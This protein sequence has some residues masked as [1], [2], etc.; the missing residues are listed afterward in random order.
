MWFSNQIDLTLLILFDQ[1]KLTMSYV[2]MSRSCVHIFQMLTNIHKIKK[3]IKFLCILI[4][5]ILFLMGVGGGE[6]GGKNYPTTPSEKCEKLKIGA[7]RRPVPIFRGLK[8]SFTHFLKLFVW[9]VCRSRDMG[10]LLGVGTIF[11]Y[12]PI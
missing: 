8:F 1:I 10:V 4:L 11:L 12:F 9:V 5:L 3:N 2:I 7:G 6:G